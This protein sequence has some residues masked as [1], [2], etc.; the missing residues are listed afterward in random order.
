[1][2]NTRTS[3]TFTTESTILLAA[4]ALPAPRR[5]I[6]KRVTANWNVN[7]TWVGEAQPSYTDTAVIDDGARITGRSL[8][9]RKVSKLVV[10]QADTGLQARLIVNFGPGIYLS[11]SLIVNRRDTLETRSTT[12]YPYIGLRGN[13]KLNGGALCV[14]ATDFHFEGSRNQVLEGTGAFTGVNRF[15][16]DK[17]D[18]LFQRMPVKI[19]YNLDFN[20]G[21]VMSYA[22]IS[23]Y[24]RDTLSIFGEPPMINVRGGKLVNPNLS[25]NA[26]Y[27]I[28]FADNSRAGDSARSI[29]DYFI[30]DAPAFLWMNKK[31][32]DT[33][34]LTGNRNLQSLGSR[35]ETFWGIIKAREQDT[36]SFGRSEVSVNVNYQ[37]SNDQNGISAGILTFNPNLF[38][39]SQYD[40][41][42]FPI[43]KFGSQRVVKVGTP[44]NLKNRGQSLS[45]QVLNQ[46]PSGTAN[47]PLSGL[48]GTFIYRITSNMDDLPAGSP[49][50]FIFQKRDSLRG[51][52]LHYRICQ[53]TSPYGPWTSISSQNRNTD[54]SCLT[55][56]PVNFRNGN[57]FCFGTV[58]QPKD[59]SIDWAQSSAPA[60]VG[61]GMAGPDI[62]MQLRN[63]GNQP[64]N[65]AY[66]SWTAGGTP[67]PV[68]GSDIINFPTALEP[69]KTGIYR[70]NPSAIVPVPYTGNFMVTLTTD[71]S[72]DNLFS[73]YKDT[74]Q[75]GMDNRPNG[76]PF[77]QAFDTIRNNYLPRQYRSDPP[78]THEWQPYEGRSFP[79]VETLSGLEI[80]A[81]LSGTR[82]YTEPVLMPADTTFIGVEMSTNYTVS[83]NPVMKPGDSVVV[84]ISLDS[85][86]TYT[87]LFIKKAPE[88]Y[89]DSWVERMPAGL[90]Y[91]F[92]KLPRPAVAHLRI[93]SYLDA[94]GS[95]EDL[96]QA[97]IKKV[98]YARRPF[99]DGKTY[100]MALDWVQTPAPALTGPGMPPHNI[101]MALR[102]TG[103]LAVSRVFV[104][105]SV[106]TPEPTQGR[107]TLIL[108]PPM[109]SG[110]TRF[111]NLHPRNYV[112]LKDSGR[113]KY[114]VRLEADSLNRY[115]DHDSVIVYHDNSTHHLP[116]TQSFDT[117]PMYFLPAQYRAEPPNLH[118]YLVI[119]QWNRHLLT[120]ARV[121]EDHFMVMKTSLDT[122]KINQVWTEPVLLKPDTNLVTLMYR[123]IYESS[124]PN[125]DEPQPGD[126]AI[127]AVSLDS[128]RTYKTLRKWTTNDIEESGASDYSLKPDTFRVLSTAYTRAHFR[129]SLYSGA[130]NG[131]AIFYRVDDLKVTNNYVAPV[132]VSE[133]LNN[134]PLYLYPNPGQTGSFRISGL[135]NV[136]RVS[137]STISGRLLAEKEIQPGQGIDLPE[138]PAGMYLVKIT[139]GG[140]SKVLKWV[141]RP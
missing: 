17:D 113:F 80:N 82:V 43:Y 38:S 75:F 141:N 20:R 127:M 132:G 100:D 109:R 78:N 42:V 37:Y 110:Q 36:V 41:L 103:T 126:S 93:T 28:N 34:Y 15:T 129:F 52:A 138:I 134:R 18:T 57:Y 76:L 101:K 96:F 74:I 123:V 99:V 79:H 81:G 86:K 98:R 119:A 83:S 97:T 8:D 46:A 85:G 72:A 53:S 61:P 30:P 33:C 9:V 130:Y 10:G 140:H 128:G 131:N 13:M 114:T 24:R 73:G 6:S 58:E 32:K 64:V 48:K 2:H 104:S 125:E 21:V 55:N 62:I 65:Q 116:F 51:N 91:G 67:G 90:Y 54:K 137:V 115:K 122:T 112:A 44:Q 94:Q 29:D 26:R 89:S 7:S 19:Q 39:Y 121:E 106:N 88:I 1:F 16:V 23:L 139:E 27:Y 95:W 136:A 11:D 5:I 63:V 50:K 87:T 124:R 47:F 84:A 12:G 49:L 3:Q 40:T 59:L 31:S 111:M 25:C 77:T 69:N 135:G 14:D 60:L 22:P 68:R 105:Y 108:D 107:D 120:F 56:S 45:V 66:I 70:L 117:I 102:N 133:Q 71:G 118:D 92:V 4:Q 35:N